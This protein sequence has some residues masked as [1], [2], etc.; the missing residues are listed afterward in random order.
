MRNRSLRAGALAVLALAG[1]TDGR[2]DQPAGPT[3]P[4][5]DLSSAGFRL[6]I[7]VASGLVTVARPAGS[8]AAGAPSFSLLGTDAIG[9]QASACTFSAIPGTSKLKRCSLQ[10]SVT[11]ASTA[12]PWSS[13]ASRRRRR[14]PTASCS[15]PTRRRPRPLPAAAR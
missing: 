14:A 15:S 7:D 9:I 8:R 1:C 12:S 6:T 11:T 4:P 13:R 2:S 5:P 3:S 10:L